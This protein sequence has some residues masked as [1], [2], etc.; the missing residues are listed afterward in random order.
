MK[1]FTTSSQTFREDVLQSPTPVVVDFTASWC[2]PCRAMAPVLEQMAAEYSGHVRFA[3]VNIDDDPWLAEQYGVT[4][5]P[6]LLVFQGGRLIDRIVGMASP[7]VMHAK[8][9][10][11]KAASRRQ[12]C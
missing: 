11:Q 9:D 10:G 8:L 4:A 3:K 2:G 6:T 5:V 7:N 12:F 1:L